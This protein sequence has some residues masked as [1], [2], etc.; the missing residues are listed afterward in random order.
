MN[1]YCINA[2]AFDFDG[3]LAESVHVKGQAFVDLYRHYPLSIRAQVLKYHNQ[4]GGVSRFDKIRY[5]E[6]ILL[7]NEV[8]EEEILK[9]A[10]EFSSLVEEQ[11]VRS[12]WVVGARDF[13]EKYHHHDLFVISATPQN[14]LE[15]ILKKRKMNSY[16]SGIFG[17]PTTKDIHLTNIIKN[18]DILPSSLLMIGDSMTDYQAAQ[19]VSTSFLGVV[20]NRESSPFPEGTTFIK[21]LSF[22][23]EYVVF[24]S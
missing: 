20:S 9:K 5:F 16:F 12:D 21:D 24:Q 3:V 6:K 23:E 1:P 10:K 14:E 22:L 4:N 2:I 19:K 8:S 7:K 17:S 11:V 15:R 18:Y 13:L